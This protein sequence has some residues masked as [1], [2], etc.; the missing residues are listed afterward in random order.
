MLNFRDRFEHHLI[1]KVEDPVEPTERIL[2]EVVGLDGWFRCTPQ[3][4]AKALL[5]RFAVAG[6]AVRYEAMR[7]RE[8]G[9]LVALDVALRRNDP[10][11]IKPV[12]PELAPLLSD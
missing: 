10:D 3:E 5:H 7:R 9:G 12:P 6:A 2:T 1:L 11:W 8:T 4:G